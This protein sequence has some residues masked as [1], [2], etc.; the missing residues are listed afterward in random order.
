[1][2]VLMLVTCVVQNF[3]VLGGLSFCGSCR[4]ETLSRSRSRCGSDLARDV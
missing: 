2:V 4:I 1:M 3:L